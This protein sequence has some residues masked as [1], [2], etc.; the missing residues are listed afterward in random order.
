MTFPVSRI[1]WILF[2]LLAMAPV[3]CG[4]AEAAASEVRAR[5]IMA[6]ID[7]LWRADSS[8][9][10]VEMKVVTANYSREV[11]MESWTLGEEKSLVRIL[12][13]RKEKGTV[14][15]K[16]GNAIYTYLPKTDRTIR[17]TASMMMGSWMGS[18]FTNDDLVKESQLAEDYLPA[19]IFEGERAG[20]EIIEFALDPKPEAP[21]VWGR[22]VMVVLADNLLPVAAHYYDEDLILARSTTFSDIREMGGRQLPA[23]LRV[24]PADKP[25]EYTELTYREI[26]F[27]IELDDSFFSLQQL[28]RR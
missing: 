17:L 1:Q 2:I 9:S 28:R 12:S 8:R 10:T 24:V 15:L 7:D 16:S 20:K 22:I 3:L 14:T 18:H 26:T 27:G 21:V 19:I 5:Q 4:Y 6:K 23:V 11:L 13:P 25:D